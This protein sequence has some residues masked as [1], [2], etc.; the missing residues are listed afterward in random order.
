LKV[1]GE[2][3][4][5]LYDRAIPN[6][7]NKYLKKWGAKVGTAYI[8]VSEGSGLPYELVSPSGRLYDAFR[9]RQQ[10]QDALRSMEGAS[11]GTGW[12]IRDKSPEDE[13]V[14]SIEINDQ[15]RK[16]FMKEGQ[17]ISKLESQPSWMNAVSHA[18]GNQAA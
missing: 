2:W 10:A 15:M 18:L 11:E 7:M 3:A 8:P 17:P 6:F 12:S 5:A 4:N 13:K 1:G 16:A 9:T 14:H